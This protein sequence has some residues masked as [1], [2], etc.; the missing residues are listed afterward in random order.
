MNTI[1]PTVELKYFHKGFK[2][3]N[4]IGLHFMGREIMGFGGKVAPPF[5]RFYMGGD[6]D[7]R[8]FNI[9]GISPVAY[10]PTEATVNVYNADGTQ[11]MQKQIINGV[12]QFSPV[13]MTIPSYQLIFPGGD[14]SLVGNAEYRIPIV[15]PITLA[16]FARRRHRQA[17]A[18]ESA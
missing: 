16:I 14:T 8:G 11:R 2:P 3:G 10:L 6:Y 5:S 7:I 1:N 15:G 9:W 4:V 12:T 18:A 13:T 17:G